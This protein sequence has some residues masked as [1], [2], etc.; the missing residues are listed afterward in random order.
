MK[1]ENV[2]K[3]LSMVSGIEKH[4]V[5]GSYGD[6]VYCYLGRQSQGKAQE[7]YDHIG[8]VPWNKGESGAQK[9]WHKGIPKGI[10]LRRLLPQRKWTGSCLPEM[11]YGRMVCF[12]PKRLG[13]RASFHKPRCPLSL[14]TSFFS[15][16]KAQRA[17]IKWYPSTWKH[18]SVSAGCRQGKV[19]SCSRPMLLR[20]AFLLFHNNSVL[21]LQGDLVPNYLLLTFFKKEKYNDTK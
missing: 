12:S 16:S 10:L 18:W 3:K 2:D 17:A 20:S 21:L 8:L 5:T 11:V 6:V 1:W 15:W 14:M 4:P 9:A 13:T 7:T 19:T